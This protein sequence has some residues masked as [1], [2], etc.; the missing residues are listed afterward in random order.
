VSTLALAV[1][2]NGNV[3]AA[4]APAFAFLVVYTI[5][6]LPLRYPWLVY[7]ALVMSLDTPA[8]P[9]AAGEYRSSLRPIAVALSSQLKNVFPSGALVMSG[10]DLLIAFTLVV[11]AVRRAK[12]STLDREGYQPTPLPLF[13]ANWACLLAVLVATG[14]GLATGGAFRWALWQI[15][16]NIYLPLMFLVSVAIFPGPANMRGYLRLLT[17]LACLRSVIAI[18][19]RF[20]YPEVEY[21]SSH[22]DS[23]LFGTVYCY[24]IIQ[25]LHGAT[26]RF[27]WLSVPVFILVGWGM[28]A[29]DRRLVYVQ[30]VVALA[31]VFF[32][33]PWTLF[34]KRVSQITIG[35]I[36]L[37]IAYIA[38]GWQSPTGIFRP[39]GTLRSMADSKS[40][41]STLWRD[42]ENFNLVTTFKHNPIMGTGF[43]HPYEMAVWLP[44]ITNS[45]ELEPYVPHNSVVGIWAYTGYIGFTL[46]W[47]IPLVGAYF[48]ARAY[49]LSKEP[50]HRTIALTCF[51]SVLIYLLQCY[52][53]MG[54]GSMVAILLISPCTAM[55]G[56]LAIQV[57]AW[58]SYTRG[59]EATPLGRG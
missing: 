42:L 48:S 28:F 50:Y 36:P 9:F 39:V 44:D 54:L 18:W 8:E 43:G 45:Y 19:L 3:V 47:M 33:S 22:S 31:F 2:T 10:L 17:A 53:D 37:L 41:G 35:S 59:G 21:T 1:L 29:N 12:G 58:P 34:K 55:V 14:W 26:R 27:K 24:L 16:R 52:G 56:K 46:M 15:Q 32:M 11:H 51:C 5:V 49:Y 23:M 40:D 57:G 6:K 25:L 4:L 20:Q 13:I 7:M 30:I 38:A